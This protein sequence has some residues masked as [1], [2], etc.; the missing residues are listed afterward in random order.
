MFRVNHY[1][2]YQD[3][4]G[5]PAAAAMMRLVARSIAGTLRRSTDR[6]ARSGNGE[7]VVSVE[8]LEEAQIK[9]LTKRI[10]ERVRNLSI[11]HPKSTSSRYVSLRSSG[12]RADGFDSIE[13]L[14]ARVRESL[15]Q[16]EEEAL[17]PVPK[18]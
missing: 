11:H 4:F 10:V 15:D 6:V 1:E 18:L 9:A 7:F 16:S 2:L 8:G 13:E 17:P 12:L 5:E 3:T 14:F